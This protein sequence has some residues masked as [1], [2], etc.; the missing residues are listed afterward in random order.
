MVICASQYSICPRFSCGDNSRRKGW[1]RGKNPKKSP[2]YAVRNEGESS[3]QRQNK[4]D[5]AGR[6]PI[7]KVKWTL[8]HGS[9]SFTTILGLALKA[10]NV[11]NFRFI[12]NI[13]TR[14]FTEIGSNTVQVMASSSDKTVVVPIGAT[15]ISQPDRSGWIYNC[16]ERSYDTG[17][18]ARVPIVSNIETGKPSR[19]PRLSKSHNI[20]SKTIN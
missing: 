6:T 17:A 4:G 8:H 20:G 11:L 14:R 5:G 9:R 12:S 3:S 16:G 2:P 7:S 1:G 10:K 19:R 18:R 15:I 13:L